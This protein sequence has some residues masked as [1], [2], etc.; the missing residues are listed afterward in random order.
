VG[1]YNSNYTCELSMVLTGVAFFH[2]VSIAVV[3]LY[4]CKTEHHASACTLAL[5]SGLLAPAFVD[6]RT[7]LGE[8]L[9]KLITCSD[10]DVRWVC[11]GVA[12]SV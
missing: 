1:G 8:A 5:Y 2:K 6:C 12:P 4:I 7:D 3:N 9:V 11:G 10:M